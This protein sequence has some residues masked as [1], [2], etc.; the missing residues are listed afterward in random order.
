MAITCACHV[1]TQVCDGFYLV[2]DRLSFFFFL[3]LQLEDG[4]FNHFLIRRK[5][6]LSPPKMLY[7]HIGSITLVFCSTVMKINAF[8]MLVSHVNMFCHIH[9]QLQ[10][11]AKH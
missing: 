10:A 6:K 4:Y 3:E 5:A 11:E 1:L 8:K 9:L 7:R 2:I